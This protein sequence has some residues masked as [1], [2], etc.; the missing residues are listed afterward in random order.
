M[1]IVISAETVISIVPT[2][3]ATFIWTTGFVTWALIVKLM[4][5]YLS[6]PSGLVPTI[7]TWPRQQYLVQITVVM[8]P[9]IGNYG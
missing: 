4:I 6:F 7:G 5:Q 8:G 2:T 9:F 3:A 1:K